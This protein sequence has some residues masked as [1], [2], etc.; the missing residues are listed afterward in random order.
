LRGQWA[1]LVR[2]RVPLS[3]HNISDLAPKTWYNIVQQAQMVQ[4]HLGIRPH[5]RPGTT[6][7]LCV[8]FSQVVQMYKTLAHKDLFI[9]RPP[10]TFRLPEQS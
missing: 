3:A 2:V 8:I 1:M 9:Q 6:G 10:M 7:F 4:H 5:P